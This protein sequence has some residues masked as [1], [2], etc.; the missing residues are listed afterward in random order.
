MLHVLVKEVQMIPAPLD[1]RLGFIWN[2][3]F[4]SS[5]ISANV[6]SLIS[7]FQQ[8]QYAQ[9]QGICTYYCPKNCLLLT[10]TTYKRFSRYKQATLTICSQFD[11]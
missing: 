6:G 1:R 3:P 8:A 5:L 9:V 7:F 2:C 10:F 11:Y 4:V